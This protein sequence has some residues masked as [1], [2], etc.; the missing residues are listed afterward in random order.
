MEEGR[1]FLAPAVRKSD[2][3]VEVSGQNTTKR[4]ALSTHTF[5]WSDIAEA[6]FV[7]IPPNGDCLYYAVAYGLH[8]KKISIGLGL[9]RLQQS[10]STNKPFMY[11]ECMDPVESK[12]IGIPLEFAPD[13][14]HATVEEG[15]ADSAK[16]G[17]SSSTLNI[18]PATVH[19]ALVLRIL[20]ANLPCRPKIYVG[21]NPRRP[22]SP[23]HYSDDY[24]SENRFRK[25]RWR[26]EIGLRYPGDPRGYGEEDEMILLS[27][28]FKVCFAVYV[29]PTVDGPV[30]IF[31]TETQ[32]AIANRWRLITAGMPTLLKRGRDDV[33]R[34][35]GEC[36]GRTI[37]LFNKGEHYS[38]LDE[39]FVRVGDDDDEAAMV[40][41]AIQHPKPNLPKPKE[42]VLS[43]EE[44]NQAAIKKML[45]EDKKAEKAEKAKK[46]EKA[47]KAKRRR[48]G[49]LNFRNSLYGS[50]YNTNNTNN[51]SNTSRRTNW[52]TGNNWPTTIDDNSWGAGRPLGGL[53]GNRHEAELAD[54]ELTDD[55]EDDDEG[56][57]FHHATV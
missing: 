15:L 46:A 55:D 37:Y 14:D 21:P 57:Y 16:M 35:E 13:I 24:M 11:F 53:A 18:L 32:V 6:T 33:A 42:P 44:K 51:T 27:I 1:V 52:S 45:E 47:E 30:S 40:A 25:V 28:L 34:L 7:Q 19:G 36:K 50:Q 43:E 4:P 29:P 9:P 39:P 26:A 56:N 41:R 48:T 8:R 3:H 54:A 12:K 22:F 31:E 5:P 49:G 20:L 17:T 23:E 10:L 2:Q 38:V